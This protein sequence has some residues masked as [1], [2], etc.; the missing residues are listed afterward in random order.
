MA[1]ALRMNFLLIAGII[2]AGLCAAPLPIP[3]RPEPKAVAIALVCA[4]EEHAA[5]DEGDGRDRIEVRRYD[6]TIWIGADGLVCRSAP[7]IHGI[8]GQ[9]WRELRKLLRD[10]GWDVLVF[11]I[12]P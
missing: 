7:P 3:R 5:P 9:P 6:A 12:L 8:Q 4:V 10:D 1:D 2:M 11:Q